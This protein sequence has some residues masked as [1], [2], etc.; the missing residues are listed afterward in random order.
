MAKES[1]LVRIC[2]IAELPPEGGVTEVEVGGVKL[3]VAKL[4]GKVAVLDNTCTHRGGPLGQGYIAE[5][6]VICPWHAYGFNL[7]TGMCANDPDDQ[8]RVFEVTILGDDVL[9]EL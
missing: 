7:V 5:G 3:C 4:N 9:V 8:V 1:N 6:N 2:R